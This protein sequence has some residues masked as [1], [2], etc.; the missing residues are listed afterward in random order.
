MHHRAI[1][2]CAIRRHRIYGFRLRIHAPPPAGS[3]VEG[4]VGGHVDVQAKIVNQ[5]NTVVL[6]GN[7]GGRRLHPGELSSRE[8]PA[9]TKAWI[10]R[11]QPVNLPGF[12][13]VAVAELQRS[14]GRLDHARQVLFKPGRFCR[15]RCLPADEAADTNTL[16]PQI[17]LRKMRNSKMYH[18]LTCK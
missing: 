4:A 8:R 3:R 13:L 10:S 2:H 1:P 15:R 6:I 16:K 5:L 12:R 17:Y 18:P 9:Q 11:V 14:S 7:V